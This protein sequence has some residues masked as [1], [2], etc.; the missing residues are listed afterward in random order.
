MNF[1]SLGCIGWDDCQQHRETSVVCMIMATIQPTVVGVSTHCPDPEM[2]RAVQMQKCA[3]QRQHHTIQEVSSPILKD[4]ST[5]SN[6]LPFL[7]PVCDHHNPRPHLYALS[8]HFC[9]SQWA[10]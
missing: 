1:G 10:T 9:T 4:L 6:P 7:R 5:I 3:G 2:A 8:A